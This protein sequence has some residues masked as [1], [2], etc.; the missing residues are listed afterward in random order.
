MAILALFIEWTRGS[1]MKSRVSDR[2]L[3]LAM[4]AGLAP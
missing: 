1:T 3:T 4:S 2:P